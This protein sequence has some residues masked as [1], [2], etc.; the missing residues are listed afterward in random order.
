MPAG[1]SIMPFETKIAEQVKDLIRKSAGSLFYLSTN[2][3][4]RSVTATAMNLTDNVSNGR[5]EVEDIILT[6]SNGMTTDGGTLRILKNGGSGTASILQVSTNDLGSNRTVNIAGQNVK[7]GEWARAAS[8]ANPY[9]Q[10]INYPTILD[11]GYRLQIDLLGAAATAA[12]NGGT[13]RVLM[14][15][16]RIDDNASTG[17]TNAA[18]YTPQ[19]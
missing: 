12:S 10:L 15:F 2:V 9:Q 3:F 11:Q 8:T 16:R 6:T 19:L 1:R 5:L 18:A 14:K 17:I 7:I 4:A 13:V